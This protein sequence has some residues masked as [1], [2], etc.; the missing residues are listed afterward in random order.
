VSG[1]PDHVFAEY[2]DVSPE[3]QAAWRDYFENV[4]VAANQ[5]CRGYAGCT[6]VQRSGWWR[7]TS[8]GP[9]KALQPHFGLRV[10][11]LRVNTSINFGALLQHE[12]TFLALH[13]FDA[14]PQPDYLAEWTAAWERLQPDW[15]DRHPDTDDPVEALSRDFFSLVDNHWDVT[16]EVVGTLPGAG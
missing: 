10:G 6:I 9:R 7:D 11:G 14:P 2:W 5:Q 15:R 8:A 12:Y 13:M 4:I 1:T 16:Y 3:N